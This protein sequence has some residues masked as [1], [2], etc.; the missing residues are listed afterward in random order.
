MTINLSC[1]FSGIWS[2][3]KTRDDDNLEKAQITKRVTRKHIA[4][5]AGVS[6]SV[7]SRALNN[8][9]YVKKEV[10]ERVLQIAEELGYIP[11]PIAMSLQQKRTKQIL[12]Y[13]KDLHNAF[14]ID[15]Y[16]GVM[17]EAKK[18]GYMAFLNANL[19]F[20]RLRDTMIDGIILQNEGLAV[21]FLETCG[22]N[23]RLPAVVAGFGSRLPMERSIP[24]VEWDLYQGMEIAIEYL[25][26]NGH[27]RIA[28]AHNGSFG[29]PDARNVAWINC[30]QP[31]LKKKLQDYH[32]GIEQNEKK[33]YQAGDRYANFKAVCGENEEDFFKEGI[34]GAKEFLR[35]GLN[36]TAILCFND[37]YAFGMIQ[38]FQ[39]QK[40]RV[41]DDVSLISFDGSY[42]RNYVFPEMNC[43]TCEP[44]YQGEVLART[45][46]D[47]IEGKPFHY[48]TRISSKLL[49][50][51]TVKNLY[52]TDRP[53]V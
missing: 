24:L 15:L 18:R 34:S 14:Y 31:Y 9:G 25:M 10:K 12:F 27:T 28:Y 41:P 43:I 11:N 7:V 49:E 46:I 19:N 6:V 17:R 36:A 4:D 20:N 44:E 16:F 26:K 35:R 50:G 53:K 30:M 8:S 3:D 52:L 47:Q 33:R 29:D 37:E 38:E 2:F 51:G 1:C 21:E 22:M 45:L 40:I 48:I 23:Y 32:L 42:R 39:R 13:C 5:L